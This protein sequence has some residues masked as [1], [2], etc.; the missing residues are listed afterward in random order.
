MTRLM[1]ESGVDH[2]WL[3]ATGIEGFAERFPTLSKTVAAV[4]LEPS[5]DWLPVA[6]AAHYLSG[7]LLTDLDGATVLP[8]LWAAG[9]AACSGV[10][11]ANRL[12]SNSL[13]DGLV[14]AT[15]VVK[16]VLR[17]KD[18]PEAT[19]ALKP[20]LGGRTTEGGV[21]VRTLSTG[22]RP[23]WKLPAGDAS[24]AR[25][26]LQ[27]SMTAGA[28]VLRSATSLSATERE[29]QALGQ[30][31]AR[32]TTQA[33]VEVA[34]LT[35]TA[36]ALLSAAQAREESRGAHTREDFPERSDEFALRLVQ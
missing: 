19:G 11:G 6:P 29:L 21:G 15:R 4:G 2:L 32:P 8:R 26:L 36:Q 16:A 1:L 28:G 27:R 20:L 14:F 3:D 10:H 30:R 13:L 5:R 17:G 23:E 33:E 18:A 12:A 7:G 9:E 35:T 34:N 24:K 25:E 31:S 22:G